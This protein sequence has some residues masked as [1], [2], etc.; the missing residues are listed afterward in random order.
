MVGQKGREWEQGLSCKTI[1]FL[2]KIFK[3]RKRKKIHHGFSCENSVQ[4][5]MYFFLEKVT[6]LWELTYLNAIAMQSVNACGIKAEG[7][8]ATHWAWEETGNALIG[9]DI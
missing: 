2:I 3:K 9:S 6:L 8:R 7:R 1:W 4:N 5:E